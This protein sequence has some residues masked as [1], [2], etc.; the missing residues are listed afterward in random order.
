MGILDDDQLNAIILKAKGEK[1]I[2]EYA[3]EIGV[4]APYLSDVLHGNRN[5][6]PK[7]LKHFGIKRTK[8]ITVEYVFTKRKQ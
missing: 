1:S 6:G 3:K 4:S 8:K 7:I 2:R 5:P